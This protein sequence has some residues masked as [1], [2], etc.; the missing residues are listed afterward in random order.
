[1]QVELVMHVS[2]GDDNRLS[3]TVRTVQ[4]PDL[5]V[6]AGLREFSGTLELMRVFEELV[7][8]DSAGPQLYGAEGGGQLPGP[9]GL[10]VQ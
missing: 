7:P 8:G 4:N 1:L 6:D 9:L 2:R 3:G 5:R 10:G